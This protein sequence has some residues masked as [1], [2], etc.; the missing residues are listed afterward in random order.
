MA[1]SFKRLKHFTYRFNLQTTHCVTFPSP[2][3]HNIYCYYSN[4]PPTYRYL[5]VADWKYPNKSVTFTKEPVLIHLSQQVQ[6]LSFTKRQLTAAQLQLALSSKK[7]E[8]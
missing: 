3:Y 7:T 8:N 5:N 4:L 1:E 6:V 2:D